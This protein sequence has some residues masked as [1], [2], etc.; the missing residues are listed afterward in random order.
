MGLVTSKGDITLDIM[1]RI[2]VFSKWSAQKA[3][4]SNAEKG[5]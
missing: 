2:L 3:I 4:E 5:G 1:E